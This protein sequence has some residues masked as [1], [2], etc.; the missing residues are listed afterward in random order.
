[1][2]DLPKNCKAYLDRVLALAKLDQNHREELV[3]RGLI[4][5]NLGNAARTVYSFSA[6]ISEQPAQLD[7][8]RARFEQELDEEY[9]DSKQSPPAPAPVAKKKK[10][11]TN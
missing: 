8:E 1:M 4:P 10:R 9:P 5:A 2:Q 11:S 3:S 7:E 6:V